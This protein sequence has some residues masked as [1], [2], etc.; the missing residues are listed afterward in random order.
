MAKRNNS[1]LG[2]WV[3]ILGYLAFKV[4]MYIMIY[5]GIQ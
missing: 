2:C 4:F 3:L 1:T 5:R